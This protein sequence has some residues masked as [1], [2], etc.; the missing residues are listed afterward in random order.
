MFTF[1]HQ[2][3]GKHTPRRN[4][5]EAYLAFHLREAFETA[6]KLN[7]VFTFR[8]GSTQRMEPSWQLERFELVTVVAS[9]DKGQPQDWVTTPSSGP[10]SEL[11]FSAS[12]GEGVLDWIHTNKLRVGVRSAF[13]LCRSVQTFFA[14][15]DPRNL[16]NSF[17]SRS[18]PKKRTR[19]IREF[20]LKE[21][22]PLPWH[23]C[24]KAKIRRCAHFD[25]L[26]FT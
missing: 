11:G 22:A 18:K 15:S 5:F 9:D 2:D 14:S 25:M 8:R 16:E 10:S 4:V 23:G 12:S 7:E 3:I 1:L 26:C 19:W 13:H 6:P 24:G 21:F 20:L 17:W